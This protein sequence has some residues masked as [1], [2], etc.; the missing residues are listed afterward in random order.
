MS[1]LT[2]VY[3]GHSD[4]NLCVTVKLG[5]LIQYLLQTDSKL[6]LQLRFPNLYYTLDPEAS[7]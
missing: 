2:P 6:D 7:N 5:K 1:G 3:L 4:T